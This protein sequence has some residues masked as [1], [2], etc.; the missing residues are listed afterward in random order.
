MIKTTESDFELFKKEVEYWIDKFHLREWRL[1]VIHK[2]SDVLKDVFA[3]MKPNWKGRVVTIG[4]SVDWTYDVISEYELCKSAF[5]EVCELLL[6]DIGGIAE[7]DICGTQRQEL[8]KSV[9][10]VIRRLEWAVWEP[11]YNSRRL[12]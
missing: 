1:R 3:W 5:H 7:I 2:D 11:D 9:H 10:A 12:M 8:E 4:L 6:T